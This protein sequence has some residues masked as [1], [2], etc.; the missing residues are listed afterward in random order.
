MRTLLDQTLEPDADYT[1]LWFAGPSDVGWGLSLDYQG[2]EEGGVEVGVLFYYD[3]NGFPRWALGVTDEPGESASIELSNFQGYCRSCPPIPLVSFSAGQISHQL[4]VVDGRPTGQSD[5]E[6]G[7]ALDPGGRWDR[8]GDIEQ[9]SDPARGLIPLPDRVEAE[10]AMV[11]I[12]VT[13]A[14]MTDDLAL[15]PH[16]TVVISEGHITALGD[17]GQV[18]IPENAIRVDGRDLFLGPG[19]SEMHLHIDHGGIISAQEAGLLMIAN[20]VTTALN[21]GDGFNIDVPGLG[22]RFRSGELIGPSFYAGQVA[23]GGSDNAGVQHTVLSPTA[24]TGYAER[25]ATSG[26]DYI[27]VYWGLTR[28]VMDQFAVE[29]LRLDLPI[30]GHVPRTQSSRDSFIDGQI[31]AAHVQEPWISSLNQQFD[32][33]LLPQAAEQYLEFG[34]YLTPTLAVFES[35][36][37]IYGGDT[38]AFNALIEREGFTYTSPFIRNSWDNY[39]NSTSIQGNGQVPGA[40]DQQFQFFLTLTRVFYEAG[41]PLLVGTDAPGF[42][43]VMSGF[44]ALRELELF[45]SAGIPPEGIYQAASA[46]AGR[47]I[48]ETLGEEPFG[49][50]E[51]GNRAELILTTGNPMTAIENL[52]RPLG[53][54]SRGRFWSQDYL[55]GELDQLAQRYGFGQAKRFFSADAPDLGLPFCAEDLIDPAIRPNH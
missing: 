1:G 21:M 42:P 47:F 50:V 38:E 23:Y 40:L 44:G 49:T 9:L 51:V 29:S 16:Q 28:F 30:I 33:T 41:V 11:I 5:L 19:M 6:L 7:Y 46:N 12:D 36:T 53:V 39:F 15:L 37:S 25:L 18:A 17:I 52:R 10:R 4:S 31:M 3:A 2:N 26:Y 54:I 35:F 22:E 24:A 45:Q 8:L 32:E 48:S 55:Q 20:G 43:G 14:P 27:K 34:V 13:V